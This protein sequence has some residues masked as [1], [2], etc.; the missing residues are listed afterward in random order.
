MSG[1]F[2]LQGVEIGSCVRTH[3]PMLCRSPAEAFRRM[4]GRDFL[5][6]VK[7]DGAGKIVTGQRGVCVSWGV[8]GGGFELCAPAW[9]YVLRGLVC[10]RGWGG[11]GCGSAGEGLRI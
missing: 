8:G 7:I 2:V 5:M 1:L 4:K 11:G 9:T 10:V 6:E 3:Q